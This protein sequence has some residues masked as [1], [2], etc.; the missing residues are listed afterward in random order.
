MTYKPYSERE[1]E[2]KKVLDNGWY[3]NVCR[4]YLERSIV[5]DEFGCGRCSLDD[6]NAARQ[7]IQ[8]EKVNEND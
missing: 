5:D 3:C 7:V 4:Q 8:V 1:F 6:W 2:N